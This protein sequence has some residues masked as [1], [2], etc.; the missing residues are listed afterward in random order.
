M[1]L[2]WKSCILW[3]SGNGPS[4]SR[5][6]A[7]FRS[8]DDFPGDMIAAFKN[9]LVVQQAIRTSVGH[10][11]NHI[12]AKYH[13]TRLSYPRH[14]RPHRKALH[15][16]CRSMAT[17]EAP[18]TPPAPVPLSAPPAVGQ[19]VEHDGKTYETVQEGGAYI[20]IPPNTQKHVDPQAKLADG[21]KAQN[22]F[23]NPIQ[24]F[25]RDLSVLSI[26]AFGEDWMERKRLR[27]EK[28][29]DR[30]NKRQNKKRK[31]AES[32]QDETVGEGEAEKLRKA[33]DGGAIVA[34][35]VKV[36]HD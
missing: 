5:I 16:S 22:V 11:H 19:L 32:K 3:G 34:K 10:K 4:V 12:T 35:D 21:E 18:P 1:L 2:E 26:K 33:E 31:L 28:N 9:N 25:N 17:T 29:K 24:Q 7:A 6:E 15:I 8:F 27:N 20:L 14:F 30:H 36:S 13:L 23:Y